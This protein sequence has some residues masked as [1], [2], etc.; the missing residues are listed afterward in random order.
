MKIRNPVSAIMALSVIAASQAHGAPQPVIVGPYVLLTTAIYYVDYAVSTANA[1]SQPTSG[2]DTIISI[3]L[4]SGASSSG[5]LCQAQ[6]FWLDW[7]GAHAGLSG[8]G[9]LPGGG[10]PNDI[11][12]GQTLEYTSS[13]NSGN[14]FEYPP[15]DENVFRDITNPANSV[16][17]FEGYAQV[18]ILCPPGTPALT[19]LRVDAEVVSVSKTPSGALSFRYKPINVTKV[20]GLVGY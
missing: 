19:Q 15:F 17:P 12:P 18:R 14:P 20:S 10:G 11:V 9:F 4:P 13:L 6:V 3:G 8:P 2:S 5:G 16:A 1:A 7:N